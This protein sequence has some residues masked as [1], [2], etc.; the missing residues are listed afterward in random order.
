[1]AKKTKKPYRDH[2]DDFVD[3]L[4][5]PEFAYEYLKAALE[6]NDMPDVF[7]DALSHVAKAKGV[8]HIASHTKLN[9]ENLY[10]LLSKDGNPTLSSLHSILDAL[11]L[12]LSLEPKKK[13]I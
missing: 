7:M 6:E 3:R 5:D 4:K 2:D 10:K 12:K 11:G 8:R 9:R 13:A 1:M